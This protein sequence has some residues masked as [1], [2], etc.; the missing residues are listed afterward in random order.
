MSTQPLWDREVDFLV[1]GSGAGGLTAAITAAA[2]GL[3]TLVIEKG[4]G[5]R[6]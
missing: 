4:S 6:R 3:S 5:L 2:S 1:V